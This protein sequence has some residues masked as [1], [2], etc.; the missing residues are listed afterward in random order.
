MMDDRDL[1]STLLSGRVDDNNAVAIA[2]AR[3]DHDCDCSF[4][5]GLKE[6]PSCKVSGR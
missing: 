6:P 4:T 1:W 3:A 5:C 2:F